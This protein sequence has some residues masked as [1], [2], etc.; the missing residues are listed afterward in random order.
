MIPIK[1]SQLY[2]RPEPDGTITTQE[3][4]VGTKWTAFS[5]GNV[6]TMALTPAHCFSANLW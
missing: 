5:C 1:N 3:E 6:A 4:I 2:M